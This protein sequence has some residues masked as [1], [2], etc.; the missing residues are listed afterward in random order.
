MSKEPYSEEFLDSVL[1]EIWLGT[2]GQLQDII[3]SI[4]ELE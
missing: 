1:S 2:G 3:L 4:M